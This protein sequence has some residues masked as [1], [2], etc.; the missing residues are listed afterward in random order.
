MGKIKNNNL[1][2]L[3]PVFWGAFTLLVQ[4]GVGF[5]SLHL[6]SRSVLSNPFIQAG[7]GRTL[8]RVDHLLPSGVDSVKKRESL[9]PMPSGCQS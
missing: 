7:D 4:V 8:G 1:A 3:G 9:L 2:N 5:F 6:K